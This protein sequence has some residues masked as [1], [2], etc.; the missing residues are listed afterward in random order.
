[1]KKILIASPQLGGIGGIETVLK[2]ILSSQL[3]REFDFEL[4]ILGGCKVN[5]RTFSELKNVRVCFTRYSGRI[6]RAIEFIRYL[7]NNNENIVICL[8]RE[9][10]MVAFYTR[11]LFNL[12]YKI[13]SWVHFSI[14]NEKTNFKK[15]ADYHLSISSGNTNYLVKR[16]VSR[17]KIFTIYNPISISDTLITSPKNKIRFIYVGRVIFE[18]QK[19]L[20]ELIDGI[21]TWEKIN[22]SISFFGTGP[23][24]GKCKEY[25]HNN[26]PQIESKFE[27][28]G[29]KSDPWGDVKKANALILTSNFEGFPMVLLEAIS[30]GLPCVSSNCM[31]GPNDIIE[32]GTNG[33]LY[34]LGNISDFH[35]KLNKVL[36]VK[37][38][39]EIKNSINKFS[40]KIYFKTLQKALLEILS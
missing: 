12:K 24:I 19:N 37:E 16:Q 38:S 2:K 20:K 35:K 27:W 26:Y 18:K 4:L 9:E 17:K 31:T 8:S 1:M 33:Y 34:E 15:Y 5:Q 10:L 22:W 3:V 40:D 21:A 39:S 13:V 30:R 36:L 23:D 6:F 28:M 25:I 11:K 14:N 29:W 32:N 7:I